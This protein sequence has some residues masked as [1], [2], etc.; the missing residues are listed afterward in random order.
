MSQMAEHQ[1]REKSG[2]ADLVGTAG[3]EDYDRLR[4]VSYIDQISICFSIDSSTRIRTSSWG[5]Q[6][7]ATYAPACPSYVRGKGAVVA[8][9][10]MAK[11][12][13]VHG[14]TGGL[15][16]EKRWR[17]RGVRGYGEYITAD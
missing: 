7:S 13:D 11:D 3:Q 10:T 15:C 1:C 2:I 17:V 14:S 5:G 12:V 6:R 16:Q 9:S 8:S 4:P